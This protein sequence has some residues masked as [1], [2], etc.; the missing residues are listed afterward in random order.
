MLKIF[1]LFVSLMLA[2]LNIVVPFIPTCSTCE[3]TAYVICEE[4]EGE[5]FI[6]VEVYYNGI[7]L[8]ADAACEKCEGSGIVDCPDCPELTRKFY[9]FKS[10]FEKSLQ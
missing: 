10:E 4:C 1:S 3:N 5:G 8:E 9:E 2:M 7:L 6:E